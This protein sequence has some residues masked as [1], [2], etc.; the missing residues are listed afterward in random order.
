M[1]SRHRP[2]SNAGKRSDCLVAL[3]LVGATLRAAELVREHEPRHTCVSGSCWA[4]RQVPGLYFSSCS[5]QDWGGLR[6]V[7]YAGSLRA[8]TSVGSGDLTGTSDLALVGTGR[9]RARLVPPT[10]LPAMPCAAY[11][12]SCTDVSVA[13][14]TATRQVTSDGNRRITNIIRTCKLQHRS[15]VR[16]GLASKTNGSRNEVEVCRRLA[17]STRSR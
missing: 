7:G 3:V 10:Q 11:G 2:S 9:A 13:R 5:I 17:Y 8:R 6:G 4:R 1:H 16:S 15:D 14:C 12:V